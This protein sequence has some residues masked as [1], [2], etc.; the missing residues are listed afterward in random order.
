MTHSH[1][2]CNTYCLTAKSVAPILALVRKIPVVN[3]LNR[4]FVRHGRHSPL[5][6]QGQVQWGIHC[7]ISQIGLSGLNSTTLSLSKYNSHG[8]ACPEDWAPF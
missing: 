2:P 1:V 5:E 4:D 3:V 7:V 8:C 6:M